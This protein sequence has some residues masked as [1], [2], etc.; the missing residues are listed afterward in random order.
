MVELA[1]PAVRTFYIAYSDDGK[2]VHYG[3]TEK[4]QVTTT[5]QPKFET[6][7]NVADCETKL[8]KDLKVS[9]A[10]LIEQPIDS[11]I[12][13]KPTEIIKMI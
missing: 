9:A 7:L 8:T 5:G 13:I 4:N 3:V 1:Y 2:V 10:K 11:K 12:E 6:F